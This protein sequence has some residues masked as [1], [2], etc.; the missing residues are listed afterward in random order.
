MSADDGF[1][2]GKCAAF[3]CLLPGSLGV[4]GEWVCF[5]HHGAGAAGWQNVTRCIRTHEPIAASTRRRSRSR[6][7]G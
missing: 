3:G 1:T 4:G 6:S 5:C 7:R 2:R